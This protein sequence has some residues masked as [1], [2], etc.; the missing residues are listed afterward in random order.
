MSLNLPVKVKRNGEEIGIFPIKEIVPRLSCNFFEPTDLYWHA[1]MSDWESLY[2][3]KDTIVRNYIERHD[4][5]RRLELEHANLM[6]KLA[7]MEQLNRALEVRLHAVR[8]EIEV[9]EA[10]ISVHRAEDGR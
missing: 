3:F 5:I 6:A 8:Q 7:E 10:K 4:L 1:G 9:I 2:L